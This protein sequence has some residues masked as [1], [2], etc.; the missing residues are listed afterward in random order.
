[1]SSHILINAV[2]PEECRIAKV[3]DNNRRRAERVAQGDEILAVQLRLAGQ[4]CAEPLA[5]A[6]ATFGHKAQSAGSVGP[7]GGSRSELL[8]HVEDRLI[9]HVRA[10]GHARRRR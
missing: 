1:M 3:K 9:V 7:A 4:A 2:D 5:A 10:G 6:P 8:R